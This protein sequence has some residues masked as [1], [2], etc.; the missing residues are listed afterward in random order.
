M[1]KMLRDCLVKVRIL[2]M[3]FKSLLCFLVYMVNAFEARILY[4]A[5][6]E[7]LEALL[8][9]YNWTQEE[10]IPIYDSLIVIAIEANSK[11]EL[12]CFLVRVLKMY[13]YRQQNQRKRTY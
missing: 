7:E 2:D 13:K 9:K 11:G 3:Y 8:R 1:A 4:P 10:I 6:M 5:Y 12:K